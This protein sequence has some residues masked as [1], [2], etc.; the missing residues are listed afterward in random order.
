MNRGLSV[1]NLAATGL[2]GSAELFFRLSHWGRF[3]HV[4]FVFLLG[5]SSRACALGLLIPAY[6]DP[7]QAANW[8]TLNQAADRVPLIA[9]MNPNNGPTSSVK[10]DYIRVVN[11]LRSS[12]GRVIG[13]IYSSYAARPLAQVKTDVD[14]YDGFYTIDGFFIDEVTNDSDAAHLAYYS[15]LYE[16]IKSKSGA[17]LVVGNPGINTLSNYLTRPTFDALVTFE[18]N[19][20]YP[21]Y[22]PDAWTQKQPATAF[23]HLCYDVTNAVTMTNYVQLAVKRNAGYVYVTDDRGNNPWDTLASYWNAEVNLVESINRQAATNQ[24]A[25]LSIAP[26]IQGLMQVQ[27]SGSPG[28]YLLEASPNLTNWGTIATN[29][30]STGK[31][32]FLD[33]QTNKY[34]IR[35]YRTAQ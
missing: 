32:N 21:A 31:F 10:P 27:V 9:I 5:E 3:I 24:P 29:V 8:E 25:V 4:L 16:Y 14:R 35:V 33:T 22:R 26:E 17:Y 7:S 20:G 13:Y 12:R 28:R 30:S 11:A 2:T 23:S 15:E 34:P 19:T 1:L 18:N 6:F